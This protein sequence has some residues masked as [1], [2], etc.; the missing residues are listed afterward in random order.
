M[1]I[2]K[3]KGAAEAVPKTVRTAD[4][5]PGAKEA[6]ADNTMELPDVDVETPADNTTELPDV[7]ASTLVSRKSRRVK[8]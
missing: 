1:L 6:P 8:Q 5:A 4:E 7:D 2:W 3:K